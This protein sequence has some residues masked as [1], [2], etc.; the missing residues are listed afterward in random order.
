MSF[1]SET[2]HAARKPHICDGCGKGIVV[3]EKYTKWAGITDGCFGTAKYHEECRA[4]EIA[5]NSLHG[6]HS[7]EWLGL[8]DMEVDDWPWLF[9]D[10]P[11]VADRMKITAQRYNEEMAERARI[12]AAWKAATQPKGKSHD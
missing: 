2:T 11:A 1:V 8:Q 12:E 4:A 7:D 5:L 6:T 10:Y 3:G 9:E